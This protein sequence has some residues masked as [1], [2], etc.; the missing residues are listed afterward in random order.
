MGKDNSQDEVLGENVDEVVNDETTTEESENEPEEKTFTQSELDK[1][2][3]DRLSREQK[4]RDEA[5]KKER[6]E[7]E[8]R[9][10]EEQSEYKALYEKAQ[11]QIATQQADALNAKRNTLLIKAGY[12]EEQVERLGRYVVGETGEELTE[13]LEALK[14][15]IP[16][17]KDYIDP[18]PMGAGRKPKPTDEVEAGRSAVSKVLH[19]IKL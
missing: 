7:A 13:S 19:K 3:A 16:P 17:K 4:K 12:S 6:D 5:V 9:Q 10:L 11:E 14:A 18:S 1:I 2:I 8:K 15:D